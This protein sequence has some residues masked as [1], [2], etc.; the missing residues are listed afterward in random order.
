MWR[1]G[2]FIL[3]AAVGGVISYFTPRILLG[4]GVPLDRWAAT[5]SQSLLSNRE[6]ALWAFTL[7]VA[8][9]LFFADRFVGKIIHRSHKAP[10]FAPLAYALDY[11]ASQTRLGR[12]VG[13][14]GFGPWCYDFA[15]MGALSRLQK[16]GLATG[17]VAAVALTSKGHAAIPVTDWKTH[18][19]EPIAYPVVH[20]SK[21]MPPTYR[22]VEVDMAAVE[23]LWPRASLLRRGWWK[24]RA[25]PR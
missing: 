22:N 4:M 18:S 12:G 5:V 9:V 2:W 8:L 21:T 25:G 13:Q 17:E 24:L 3:K 15:R 11:I 20:P 1:I 16:E 19:I 6:T 7:L 14:T 10:R 23:R